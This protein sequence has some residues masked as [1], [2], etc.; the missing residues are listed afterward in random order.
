MARIVELI[1][2]AD[3]RAAVRALRQIG[4]SADA[5][6]ARMDRSFAR[7]QRTLGATSRLFSGVGRAV[8]Y[9]GTGMAAVGYESVKSAMNFQTA[10]ERIHTQAQVAQGTVDQLG[11]AVLDLGSSGKVQFGPTQLA[12]ALYHIESVGVGN[13]VPGLTKVSNAMNVLTVASKGAAIGGSDLEQ[14]TSALMGL[15]AALHYNASQA[16][17]AMDLINATVG[18]GNMKMQD[19]VT[20]LGRGVIPAF[21]NVGLT[22]HDAMAAI[23]LV[24]DQGTNASSAA[25]QLATALHYLAG[26]TQRAQ[27]LLK[28]L[29]LSP[30]K[31]SQD[32]AGPGGLVHALKDVQGAFAGLPQWEK[33][34]AIFDILPGGRGRILQQLL[35]NV[36]ALANKLQA[37]QKPLVDTNQAYAAQQQTLAGKLH[38]AWAIIQSD[39]TKFGNALVP[40]IEHYLPL[41]MK[42]F[43]KMFHWLNSLSAGTK[44]FLAKLTV[45]FLVGGPILMG[46]GRALSL[47]KALRDVMYGIRGAGAAAAEGEALAAGGGAAGAGG[48]AVA[49]SRAGPWGAL[50][51]LVAALSYTQLSKHHQKQTRSVISKVGGN[52][53]SHIALPI[54]LG[55]AI[56]QLEGG[57]VGRAIG[58][59]YKHSPFGYLSDIFHWG[60]GGVVTAKGPRHLQ[61][62]GPIGSD[63]VPAWLSPGEG[64]LNRVAMSNIGAGGLY[65]MNS[66]MGYGN[67]TIEP[68]PVILYLDGRILARAVLQQALRKAARGPSTLVGGA[69]TTNVGVSGP[70]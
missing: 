23:A 8:T 61:G 9:L 13:T 12:N 17:K 36:P 56:N 5:T 41:V 60:G 67:I 29:G 62:G 52:I 10:M 3:N 69:L 2:R 68:A 7:S 14:T 49:G 57:H 19:L 63:Y 46:I 40:I 37:L 1:F 33:N 28:V 11:K 4:D 44:D 26:P 18:A 53:L 65:A 45:G 43:E 39:I 66:G 31:L 27:K 30:L 59:I 47:F 70:H 38:S 42:Y 24:A 25:A 20:A 22:A 51:A 58:Q 32:L 48:A 21:L 55:N 16:G 54:A 64:V 50:A 35:N 15:M 6:A 34:V